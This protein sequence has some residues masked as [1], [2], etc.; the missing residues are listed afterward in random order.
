[1]TSQSTSSIASSLSQT[2]SPVD[3]V[4]RAFLNVEHS[5]SGQRWVSRLDQAAQNRALAISQIHGIPELVARVLAGR[6][7]TL[8]RLVLD[9]RR[10][11]VWDCALAA[12]LHT[13]GHA[14]ATG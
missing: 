8:G 14:S 1:M 12:T 11:N 2:T 5:V 4:P 6:G 10:T 9:L 3:P 13:S 7:V